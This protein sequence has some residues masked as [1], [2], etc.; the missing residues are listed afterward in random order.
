MVPR[1]QAQDNLQKEVCSPFPP[2]RLG[3]LTRVLQLGSGYLHPDS[4]PWLMNLR[5]DSFPQVFPLTEFQ[6]SVDLN[7]Q[8]FESQAPCWGPWSYCCQPFP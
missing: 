3:R 2:Y 8:T 6:I 7:K 4:S 1:W 5:E